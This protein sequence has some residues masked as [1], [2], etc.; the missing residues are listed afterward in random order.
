H[1][2]RLDVQS[3]PEGALVFVDGEPTGLRTPVVLRGLPVDRTLRLRVEKPGF[4]SKE[5]D[6]ELSAGTVATYTFELVASD[7]FVRFSGAPEN[8]RIYVDDVALGGEPGAPVRLSL[9]R[10]VVRVETRDA[11]VFSGAVN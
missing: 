11:L 8:A 4:A 10:H 3:T 9:G 7:G 6:V 2:G 1:A 5:Q